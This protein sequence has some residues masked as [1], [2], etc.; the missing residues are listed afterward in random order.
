MP[1]FLAPRNKS[2]PTAPMVAPTPTASV[3][4]STQ[5]S[6]RPTEF[7]N[8]ATS[9]MSAKNPT[10]NRIRELSSCGHRSLSFW[11]NARVPSSRSFG[12]VLRGGDAVMSNSS[13]VVITPAANRGTAAS[14][15]RIPASLRTSDWPVM[16]APLKC[17][18]SPRGRIATDGWMLAQVEAGGGVDRL[19]LDQGGEHAGVADRAGGL[20]E[21]VAVEHGQVGPLAGGERAGG[22]LQPVGVGGAGGER[23]QGG[24]EV[25]PLGRQ[26]RLGAAV[27][28]RHP[29]DGDLQLQQRVG[30]ADRPVAAEGE[31]RAGAP[32]ARPRGLPGGPL[33]L[34]G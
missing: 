27:V 26:E 30:G 21:G 9:P 8:S 23:G 13:S 16:F 19:A 17:T 2:S 25:Q 34:H 29:V 3:P 31:H 18:P 15:P 1:T 28:G 20:V 22:G 14:Q 11:K 7:H 5:G 12:A 32:Q 10:L 4:S 6:S 33:R 24:G